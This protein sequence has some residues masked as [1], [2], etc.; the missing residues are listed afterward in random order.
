MKRTQLGR[1]PR[2]DFESAVAK[3]VRTRRRDASEE[4]GAEGGRAGLPSAPGS[5]PERNSTGWSGDLAVLTATDLAT[6]GASLLLAV[7]D[8]V[9]EPL[10]IALHAPPGD[11]D[12]I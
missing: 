2:P 6:P 7:L 12:R 11:P 1:P 5:A 10:Q 9:A 4:A 8:E 3:G